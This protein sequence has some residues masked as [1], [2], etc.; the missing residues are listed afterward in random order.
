MSRGGL[1]EPA[2]DELVLRL[3]GDAGR[4][5]LAELWRRHGARIR[6]S[7]LRVLRNPDAA[8]DAAQ[9][10]ILRAMRHLED[11]E[12]RDFI[13]WLW[14]IARNVCLNKLRSA[15]VR[16]ET[17]WPESFDVASEMKE[18]GRDREEAESLLALLE[19]LPDRQRLVLKLLYLEDRSYEEIAEITGFSLKEVKSCAQNGRRMLR[20]RLDER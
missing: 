19:S 11:F 18:S 13:G 10:T 12:A 14:T 2:D 20:K 15:A 17:Q 16:H 1:S 9:E 5:A 7:C 6:A 8:D 3:R 4:V